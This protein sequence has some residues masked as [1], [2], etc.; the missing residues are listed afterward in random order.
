MFKNKGYLIATIIHQIIWIIT[1]SVIS[2]IIYEGL[3][4][5]VYKNISGNR[6]NGL[7][8]AYFSFGRYG[9]IVMLLLI[10]ICGT[11]YIQKK[12]FDKYNQYIESGLMYLKQECN[13]LLEF[14]ESLS[15]ERDVFIELRNY[16]KELEEKY[17]KEYQEK[18]DLLTYLAHD[19]KTPIANMMGYIVL[20]NEEKDISEQNRTKFI[21]IIY[22]NVKY[23]NQLTEE[24]FSYLKF[25]LNDIPVNLTTFNI[26][27]FFR[28]WEDEKRIITKNHKLKLKVAEKDFIDVQMDAQL[29]L[30]ILDNLIT[31]A[32]NY[33]S[34]DSDIEVI[35]DTANDMLNINILNS[36]RKDEIINWGMV[37]MKF[38]R[39]DLSRRI[40]ETGSGLGL[41]IVN[42]IANHLGGS[43]EINESEG[44]VC[45]KVILP[46]KR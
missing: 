21:N 40:G 1:S 9:I 46:Y 12:R 38:Y 44:K 23:L 6:F 20:L 35:I 33:S 8:S 26:G 10:I 36:I 24:F 5:I 41:A 39:G 19:I 31:N 22:E 11:F 29:L 17:E 16:N 7:Y 25:S 27:I 43:F 45:A 32:I 42:D 13:E 15:A 2:M 37:K 14:H 34:N 4:T 3:D 18:T 30:R 28:Q